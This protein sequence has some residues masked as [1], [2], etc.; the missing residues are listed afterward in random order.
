MP[1]VELKRMCFGW[2]NMLTLNLLGFFF[3]SFSTTLP[4]ALTSWSSV[5]VCRTQG[6]VSLKINLRTPVQLIFLIRDK[7]VSLWLCFPSERMESVPSHVGNPGWE[8]RPLLRKGCH[9]PIRGLS[10]WNAGGTGP[11]PPSCYTLEGG[12]STFFSMGRKLLFE[13]ACV[14]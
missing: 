5:G 3:S 6:V 10:L 2:S 8:I 13:E 4:P 9:P 7:A 11:I 1:Q 14:H 12:G